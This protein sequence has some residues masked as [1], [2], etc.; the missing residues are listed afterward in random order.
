MPRGLPEEGDAMLRIPWWGPTFAVVVLSTDAAG[1]IVRG[2]VKLPASGPE[3]QLRFEDVV[4]FVDSLPPQVARA[5]G[6]GTRPARVTQV[7]KHFEPRVLAT[8]AG[9]TVQF[10]N[11]DEVYHNVFSVS[12]AKHFDLGKYPPHA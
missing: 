6:R 7:G 12:P 11:R 1:G 9:T 2:E 8:E 3:A 10:R 5:W 4:V